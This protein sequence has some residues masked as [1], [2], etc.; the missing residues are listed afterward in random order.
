AEAELRAALAEQHQS[1]YHVELG[2]V[3]ARQ[4]RDRE[5]IAA[6][7]AAE[8]L[9]PRD[10]RIPHALGLLHRRTGD[11]ASSAAALG[12]ALRLEPRHTPSAVRLGEVLLESGRATEAAE[13]FRY[14]LQNDPDN[15]EAREGLMRAERP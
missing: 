3:L 14:A 12:R 8:R 9:E 4:N 7:L 5:A 10:Y 2:K 1:K 11:L 6:Y 15:R 13:A